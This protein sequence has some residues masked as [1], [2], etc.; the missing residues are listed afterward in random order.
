[1]VA[2]AVIDHFKANPECSLGIV[3]L[4]IIGV[5]FLFNAIM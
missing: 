2:R 1:V 4:G 3:A 5:G